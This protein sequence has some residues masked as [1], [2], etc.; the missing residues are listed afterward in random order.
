[1]R[2]GGAIL[3]GRPPAPLLTCVHTPRLSAALGSKVPQG[4]GCLWWGWV[5]LVRGPQG[6]PQLPAG[7]LMQ[8]SA[9]LGLHGGLS[10]GGGGL[11]GPRVPKAPSHPLLRPLYYLPGSRQLQI[12]ELCPNNLEEPAPSPQPTEKWVLRGRTP[13]HPW[14]PA[15]PW[16]GQG[17][18]PHGDAQAGIRGCDLWG[19]VQ[20][21]CS[22]T[23]KLLV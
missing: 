2:Q 11:E 5:R 15:Q 19:P 1:M 20:S 8:R 16:V 23:G 22:R 21:P 4:V 3:A 6:P 10:M 9:V 17:H 12:A 7:T 14:S 13:P 18:E